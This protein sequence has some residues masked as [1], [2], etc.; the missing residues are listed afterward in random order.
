MALLKKH[1][2][3]THNRLHLSNNVNVFQNKHNLFVSII[4]KIKKFTIFF[5]QKSYRLVRIHT[6]KKIILLTCNGNNNEK[7]HVS[8]THNNNNK[9]LIFLWCF[10]I[11]HRIGFDSSFPYL[12]YSIRV[13]SGAVA[14]IFTMV[15]NR[16]SILFL[17]FT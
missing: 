9:L 2:T 10:V 6:Q 17:R 7:C 1:T 8:F 14:T 13:C 12:L 15:F 5:Y 11:P 16:F 4:V 3:H